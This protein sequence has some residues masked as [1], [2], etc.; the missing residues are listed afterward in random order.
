MPLPPD[1]TDLLDV[2]SGVISRGQA[3]RA[4]LRP[5][6]IRRLLRRREWA[7]AFTG[8]YVAHTG[9]LT[10]LERAWVGV[11]A[12]WPAALTHRSAIRAVSGPGLRGHDDAGPLHIAVDRT[13][14]SLVPPPGVVLHHLAD[15]EV[16]THWTSSP[17]RIR[18]EHAVV[19]VAAEAATD[20]RAIA[21][22]AD[23]VQGRLT[24]AARLRAALE[25]R[26]RIARRSLL[27]G[28]LLDLELGACSVL[29]HGYLNRVE[30]PHGLLTADRQ[31]RDSLRG[32]IY[33]DV[34]YADLGLEVELDG[35]L[36]HNTAT[37]RDLDLDRDLDTAVTGRLT[38]RLGWGQVFDRSCRT[39]AALGAIARGRGWTGILLA[40]PNCPDGTVPTI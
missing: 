2:Q 13:R 40:C 37:A 30:R 25:A 16:K 35:R 21:T 7:V 27:G 9:E 11:L 14:R 32:P 8:V 5:H 17:P 18:L 19:D 4:G 29:E 38:V 34:E 6:D 26:S 10:W 1:V 3:L 36:F 33:R 20:M 28:V 31:V 24:T 39:A 15:L 12:A 23:A 22:L